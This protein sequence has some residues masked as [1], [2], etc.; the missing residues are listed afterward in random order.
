VESE[1]R[2]L[3]CAYS[4]EDDAGLRS[5][6][7]YYDD[8]RTAEEGDACFDNVTWVIREGI[9]AR[10]D[11]YTGLTAAFSRFEDVQAHV[12]AHNESLCPRPCPCHTVGRDDQKCLSGLRWAL[13]TGIAHHPEW[14]P[15]LTSSSP[16]EA[17]QA[18]LHQKALVHDD[19]PNRCPR[20]CVAPAAGWAWSSR[21][22][23]EK[24]SLYC[25]ALIRPWGNELDL[26][27]MQ[28][29]ERTGIFKCD[30]SDVYSNTKIQIADGIMTHTINSTLQC[31]ISSSTGTAANTPIFLAFWDEVI[32]IGRFNSFDWTVKAD[33][34]SVFLP[35]RLVDILG[36]AEFDGSRRKHGMFL[37][38]CGNDF[39][40][41]IEV[42]SR[43]A[44]LIYSK[45]HQLCPWHEQEDWFMGNCLVTLKVAAVD[46]LD[47]LGEKACPRSGGTWCGGS[48][49]AFHP[50]KVPDAWR[51]CWVDANG[52]SSWAWKNH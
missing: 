48:K 43:E 8:C 41:P 37:S 1:E 44:V 34:D 3:A 26:A 5:S 32:R 2:Q 22:L 36:R 25:I 15:G 18:L 35:W 51:Q 17:V 31:P 4:V 47:L 11:M 9:R 7:V 14:Y 33:A 20:P 45:N 23:V 24:K 50:Y 28:A 10:P 46:A 40:G 13:S 29:H 19:D 6:Q 49:A 12:H 39:H 38:T 42:L 52:A 21:P 30:G 16:F 27:K